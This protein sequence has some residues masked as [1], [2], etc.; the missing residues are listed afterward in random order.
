MNEC[1]DR[2]EGLWPGREIQAAL[3][4]WEHISERCSRLRLRKWETRTEVMGDE[5][6]AASCKA[7][8]RT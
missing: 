6:Q 4:E 2:G 3:V 5:D 7:G 8:V 1:M